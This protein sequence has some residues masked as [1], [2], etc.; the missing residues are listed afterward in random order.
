MTPPAPRITI[1]EIRGM[2]RERFVAAFGKVFERSPWV[3]ERAYAAWPFATLAA[4]HR[5]MVEAVSAAGLHEQLALIRAH[6]DLADGAGIAELTR[7][8]RDE[9]ASAGLDGCSPAEFE[10]FQRLN[11]AYRDRFA[12]PFI[13]AVRNSNRVAI[14]RVFEERLESD[15]V[16]EF[17]RALSEIGKIAYFRLDEMVEP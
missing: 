5:S 6:P 15:R 7:D 2:D 12:F 9:Q 13:L 3:A 8:S 17:A 10:R 4:L 14:L 1:D 16:A 11:R